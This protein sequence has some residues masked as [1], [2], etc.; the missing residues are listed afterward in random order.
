MF[1]TSTLAVCMLALPL[2]AVAQDGGYSTAEQ[3]FKVFEG[4][5]GVTE[6][7]RRNHTKGFCIVGEFAPVD[8]AILKYT[9]S[10]IFT[11]TSAVNGRVS[12]KG[13]SNTAPDD[14]FGDL[15]LAFELT[16][17]DD[18]Y[19]IINVN[20]EYFF[21]ASTPAD[22]IDVVRA[23][24]QGGEAVKAL[25]AERPELAAYLHYHKKVRAKDLHPYEGTTFNS[26]NAFYLV[27]DAGERTPI[28]WAMVPSGEQGIVSEH[29]PDFFMD[30][31][32]ANLAKGPVSWDMVVTIANA[33]DDPNNAAIRWEGDHT[34]ITAARL[35]VT[36]TATEAEGNCDTVN[37]DPTVL[38]DGFEVS[39]DPILE[40]RSQIYAH[41]VGVRLSEKD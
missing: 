36:S 37:Y 4:T 8:A 29:N 26:V 30:N 25:A 41:G 12:H 3:D 10:P 7:K 24:G 11:Q 40:A 2:S 28:R 32:N 19:H 9:N 17:A 34:E 22:F 13:G 39:D 5:F 35:T 38:S 27:N 23:K 21:P 6:G 15:G 18:D 20:T 31:M 1:K 14:K 33:D 16:T